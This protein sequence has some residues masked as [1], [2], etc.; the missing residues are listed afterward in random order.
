VTG[1]DSGVDGCDPSHHP[2][3]GGVISIWTVTARSIELVAWRGGNPT[4][5]SIQG[6]KACGHKEPL[7]QAVDGHEPLQWVHFSTISQRAV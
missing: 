2:P 6:H 7:G 4:G 5:E 3:R 1:T